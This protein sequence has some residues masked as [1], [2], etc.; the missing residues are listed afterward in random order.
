MVDKLKI[1]LKQTAV[2]TQLLKSPE[3]TAFLREKAKE[4]RGKLGKGYKYN[5]KKGKKRAN[6]MI[7]TDTAEAAK[8]NLEN[9]SLLKAVS[10]LRD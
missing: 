4:C 6:A 8:D 9:N 3:V 2:R 10:S 1:E 5:T 7:Y